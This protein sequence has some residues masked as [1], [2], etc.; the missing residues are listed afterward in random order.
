MLCIQ[1]LVHKDQT[2]IL[3]TFL[4]LS[5]IIVL[6]FTIALKSIQLL[7]PLKPE[8]LAYAN[9]NVCDYRS[10]SISFWSFY[11]KIFNPILYFNCL[12]PAMG[13]FLFRAIMSFLACVTFYFESIS[14]ILWIVQ[15]KKITQQTLKLGG[16]EKI[17]TAEG[18]GKFKKFITGYFRSLRH[19]LTDPLGCWS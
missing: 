18:Y 19:L 11:T 4:N 1:V 7:L 8:D 5:S 15:E 13:E 3:T 17:C 10:E 2:R 14:R 16:L 12:P 9:E 6:N